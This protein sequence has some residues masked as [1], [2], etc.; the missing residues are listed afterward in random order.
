MKWNNW[1]LAGLGVWSILSPWILGFSKLNIVSWN[2][3]FVGTLIIVLVLWNM[4]PPEE[5]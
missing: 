5:K 1:F 4:S 3:I 2:S